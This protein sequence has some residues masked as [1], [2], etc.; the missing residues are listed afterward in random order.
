ML[1]VGGG[2]RMRRVF[3]GVYVFV[4]AGSPFAADEGRGKV[5]MRLLKGG[6]DDLLTVL[7]L[8]LRKNGLP[9]STFPTFPGVISCIRNGCKRG[10]ALASLWDYNSVVK[11]WPNSH[12]AKPV[13]APRLCCLPLPFSLLE[14]VQ[15]TN[16]PTQGQH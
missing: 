3:V 1:K 10:L 16:H 7:V 6:L 13:K 9:K 11:N 15:I 2:V 4:G 5:G 14:G 12:K 8:L